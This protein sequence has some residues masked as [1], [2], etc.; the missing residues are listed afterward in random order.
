L[1][2]DLNLR[3]HAAFTSE[4]AVTEPVQD[5]KTSQPER[6]GVR[7]FRGNLSGFLRQVRLGKSFLV[8]SHDQVVA[9]VRPPPEMQRPR[10]RPGALRGKIRMEPDFDVL[11]Q[12][13]LMTMEGDDE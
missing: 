7:E 1:T 13:V 3:T 11:P 12:D 5:N 2:P 8:M 10:R 4:D 9:E 6:V